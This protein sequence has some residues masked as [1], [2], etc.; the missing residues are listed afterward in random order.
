MAQSG[1]ISFGSHTASHRILTTL[2]DKE[3]QD[4]LMRS[5][6]TLIAEK[7]VD[8]SFVP[9]SYPNGNYNEKIVN[10]VREAGYSLAVTTD[11]GWNHRGFNPFTL[12]RVAIHQGIL[13]QQKRCLGVESLEYYDS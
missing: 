8:S 1:L 7:A 13:H 3:I 6:E 10:M 5:K 12:R 4:E 11:N 2:T 9:F